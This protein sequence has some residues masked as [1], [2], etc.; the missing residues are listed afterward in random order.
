[1]HKELGM[2]EAALGVD[3]QNPNG[4]LALY[5]SMGFRAVRRVTTYRK[6][7]DSA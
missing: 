4:A 6:L 5:E 7:L 2:T 3:A 1:L